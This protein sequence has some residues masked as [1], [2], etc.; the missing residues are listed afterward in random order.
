MP[1]QLLNPGVK[2]V[3]LGT[4]ESRGVLAQLDPRCLALYEKYLSDPAFDLDYARSS[5]NGR[6]R[7]THPRY[8]SAS[9]PPP[10]LTAAAMASMGVAANALL[11]IVF[12]LPNRIFGGDLDRMLEFQR[13]AAS[14]AEYLRGFYT[15]PLLSRA[16]LFA[17]PDLILTSSG[18]SVVEMNISAPV[19]GLGICDRY[20]KAF[21]DDNL[22]RYLSEHDARPRHPPLGATWGEIVCENCRR[23]RKRE[24]PLLLELVADP[25]NPEDNFSRP[26]FKLMACE[27]GF[28]VL[29][30]HTSQVRVHADGVYFHDQRADVVY[31][32]FVYA[33]QKQHGVA[34]ELMTALVQAE[35]DGLVDLFMSPA[36]T[37]YDSKANLAV[38]TSDEFAGRF[39]PQE[40]ALIARHVPKTWVLSNETLDLARERRPDLVLKPASEFGGREVIFGNQVSDAAWGERLRDV[41]RSAVPYVVQAMV[42]DV[43]VYQFPGECN[44]GPRSV[45]IGPIILGGRHAGTLVRE[46]ESRGSAVSINVSRGAL[47]G[48]AFT[49]E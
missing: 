14:D 44:S 34:P 28:D 3:R 43:A 17:R 23:L 7:K 8:A 9:Y 26:D 27:S 4:P 5:F 10:I 32:D 11:E 47:W 38:M 13:V 1:Q 30:A 31:T 22:Y 45:C 33:E 36:Y 20:A 46:A 49:A 48:T 41:L 15:E 39:T 37:L 12:S 25:A 42:E 18:W 2:K 24:C 21:A 19:G 35:E 40:R 29:T 6:I 16:R